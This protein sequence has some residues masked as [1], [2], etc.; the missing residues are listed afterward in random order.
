M[1]PTFRVGLSAFDIVDNGQTVKLNSKVKPD[2]PTIILIHGLENDPSSSG[3]RNLLKA[4]RY[5]N[6]SMQVLVVDW[7]QGAKVGGLGNLGIAAARIEATAGKVAE[8][9]KKYKLNPSKISLIGHSLGAH[10]SVDLALALQNRNLGNVK[11]ITLLDPAV[12][13]PTGYTVKNLSDI[14]TSTFIR[15][16][17]TSDAGSASFAASANESYTVKY[18][19]GLRLPDYSHGEAMT[20]LANS[21]QG[22]SKGNRNCIAEQFIKLDQQFPNVP[23][24]TERKRWLVGTQPSSNLYVAY[25]SNNWLY[26]KQIVSGALKINPEKENCN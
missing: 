22:D 25:D 6:S 10:V 23:Q 19:I 1:T 7:G 5:Y 20:L 8:L 2:V 17:Y 4:V 16:F 13:M 24:N 9:I 15:S 26:P 18:P 3:F 14:S 12:D 21:F 11:S